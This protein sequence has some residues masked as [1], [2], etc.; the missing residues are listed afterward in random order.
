MR[1][2]P[3]DPAAPTPH[4]WRGFA[5]FTA[6][7]EAALT[8]LSTLAQPLRFQ[9][10]AVLFQRGDPGDW[11][12][13]LVSGRVKLTL[14]T[15]QGRELTLRHA[16]GG[17]SLGEVALVDGAAR[18]ADATAVQAGHGW[19]LERTRFLA[20]AEAHPA[21]ML[22]AA[23]YF[24]ERLRDT[25]DRLEGIALYP[26]EARLARFF[27]LTL[28]QI[29]GAEAVPEGATL[30]LD[31]SQGELAALLG[32]SRP[33]VNRALQ[34]LQET[35]AITREGAVWRCDAAALATLAEPEA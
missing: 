3:S 21:L 6:A 10:G 1:P 29:H 17:D 24:C 28:H 34:A 30:R 26:L 2:D 9:A 14:L 20:L 13:V 23:R 4:F 7:P 12:L 11:M 8:D 31:I 15:P 5:M 22:A 35:E 19:R 27:L 18:S 33:K 32:A 16:E 25:T